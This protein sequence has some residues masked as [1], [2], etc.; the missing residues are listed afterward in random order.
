MIFIAY[1]VLKYDKNEIFFLL[2][3]ILKKYYHFFFQLSYV[4]TYI[5]MTVWAFGVHWMQ[6]T[7][8]F[9]LLLHTCEI[10]LFTYP[11][12][13]TRRAEIAL[14]GCEWQQVKTL[15]YMTWEHIGTI[16]LIKNIIK[17]IFIAYFVLKYD[18][19]EIFKN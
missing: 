15:Y 17:V 14:P 10:N 18:K 6:K 5:I 13:N 4:G 9:K 16:K 12:L 2:K 11:T 19:N 7:L 1:F 8:D 3:N